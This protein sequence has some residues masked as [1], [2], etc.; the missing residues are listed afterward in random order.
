[1]TRDLLELLDALL[2]VLKKFGKQIDQPIIADHLR[3][4]APEVYALY[5]LLWWPRCNRKTC[6]LF[7]QYLRESL[8]WLLICESTHQS[9]VLPKGDT[10]VMH[11]GGIVSNPT[12]S[13]QSATKIYKRS[14]QEDL[15][16]ML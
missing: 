3:T 9:S 12:F 16:K 15:E 8:D 6:L 4:S 5:M 13:A 1:M 11:I 10:V 2:W 14:L 7:K